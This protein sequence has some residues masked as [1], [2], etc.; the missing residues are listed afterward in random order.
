MDGA[1]PYDPEKSRR[2]LSYLINKGREEY[3]VSEA[4]QGMKMDPYEAPKVESGRPYLVSTPGAPPIQE[5]SVDRELKVTN[6][7]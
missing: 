4:F 3:K 2:G 7:L 6:R 5:V 1:R